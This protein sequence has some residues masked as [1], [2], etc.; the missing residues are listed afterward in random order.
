MTIFTSLLA[1]PAGPAI[2]SCQAGEVR[3]VRGTIEVPSTL[4]AAD[5]VHLCQL[6]S[7]HVPV[8]CL[9]ESDDLDS[10]AD[11]EMDVGITADDVGTTEDPD[12][13]ID[14]TT[15]GQAGG[16]ARM[17]QVAALQLAAVDNDRSVGVTVI[18]VAATGVAG[19]LSLTLLYRAKRSGE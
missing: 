3:A 4:A 14:G 1:S 10:V 17:D 12:C 11:L 13:F 2:A 5:V 15:V 7:G 16:L 9:L 19:T 6:P 8:D 18:T